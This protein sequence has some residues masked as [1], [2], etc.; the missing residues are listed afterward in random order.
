MHIYTFKI[1]L[2]HTHINT[3]SLNVPESILKQS[4]KLRHCGLLFRVQPSALY[5]EVLNKCFFSSFWTF[6]LLTQ[7][8]VWGELW[9]ST[10]HTHLWLSRSTWGVLINIIFKQILFDLSFWDTRFL[11]SLHLFSPHIYVHFSL[12]VIPF[13]GN[14]ASRLP[15]L[16]CHLT[17]EDL[18]A[19]RI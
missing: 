8:S 10:G 7:K 9:L 11:K 12:C 2:M 14:A 18:L 13:A 1:K 19:H 15:V 4:R 5:N 16:T 3:D 6:C 17:G